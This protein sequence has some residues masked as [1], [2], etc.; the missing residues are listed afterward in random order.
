MYVNKLYKKKYIRSCKWYL[1]KIEVVTLIISLK[2][3]TSWQKAMEDI[4]SLSWIADM[5]GKCPLTRYIMVGYQQ[6]VTLDYL[7]FLFDRQ[8]LKKNEPPRY[9]QLLPTYNVNSFNIRVSNLS[10]KKKKFSKVQIPPVRYLSISEGGQWGYLWDAITR[11]LPGI[12]AF[13]Y[14]ALR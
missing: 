7:I 2:K 8:E 10:K 1:M 12:T 3:N 11:S 4:N 5:P 14:S 9:Y 6:R 13:Y